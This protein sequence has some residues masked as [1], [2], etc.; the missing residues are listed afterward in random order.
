M[1]LSVVDLHLINQA[2]A[3]MGLLVPSKLYGIMAAG[4]AS[5]FVGRAEAEVGR[6]L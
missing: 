3:M 5:V 2:E 4:R 1:P 6:V